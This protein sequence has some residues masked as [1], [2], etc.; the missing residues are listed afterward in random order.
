MTA[1]IQYWSLYLGDGEELGYV[2]DTGEDDGRD[3][4]LEEQE[5][6]SLATQP[7]AHQKRIEE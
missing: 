5:R 4:I 7:A 2:E 1:G 6:F 3:T